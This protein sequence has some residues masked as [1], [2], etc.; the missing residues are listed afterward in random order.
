MLREIFSECFHSVKFVASF[1]AT[2]IGL[3]PEKA[4]AENK[5]TTDQLDSLGAFTS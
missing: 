4:N 1:N 5:E 2:F 3:I